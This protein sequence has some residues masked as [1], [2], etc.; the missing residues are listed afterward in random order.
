MIHHVLLVAKRANLTPAEE[1]E[2]RQT[3]ESLRAI[4]A[5][6]ELTWGEDFS[7]RGKGYTHAAVMRF[8]S[9]EHLARYATDPVHLDVVAALDR[10]APERLVVDY[11]I[12]TSANSV[13]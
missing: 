10:L 7:G 5:V 13:P 6:G 3:L 1:D 8:A 12:G 2:F 4:E 11:E 9:R